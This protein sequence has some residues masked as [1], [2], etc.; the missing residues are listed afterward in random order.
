MAKKNWR[1][2]LDGNT[3]ACGTLLQPT[4]QLQMNVS[5]DVSSCFGDHML[6]SV[7]CSNKNNNN[8]KNQ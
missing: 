3:V 1:Q 8:N 7:S 6:M 4:W 5:L 2:F